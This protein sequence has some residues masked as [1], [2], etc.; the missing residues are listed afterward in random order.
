MSDEERLPDTP[1]K[2]LSQNQGR[3]G[4]MRNEEK[5]QFQ[6]TASDPEFTVEDL[7]QMS[8]FSKQHIRTLL[9]D[10]GVGFPTLRPRPNGGAAIKTITVRWSQLRKLKNE[11]GWDS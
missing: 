10:A 11:F 5:T 9:R 1:A 2:R 7:A 8:G 4:R 3:Q 6:R